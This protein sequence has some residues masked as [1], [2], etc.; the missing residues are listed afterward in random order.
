M[1]RLIEQPVGDGDVFDG[2][3][4]FV[5]VHY[6]L[7]VY[8]HF[9]EKEGESVPVHTEVEGRVTPLDHL[10]RLGPH[11]EGSEWTLHLA[12]GRILEFTIVN[13]ESAIRSTGRG[14]SRP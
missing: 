7:S 9:S 1:Q 14:L 2:P 13:D 4:Y 12:D 8:G 6:H 5:R 3:S 10:K 11:Q